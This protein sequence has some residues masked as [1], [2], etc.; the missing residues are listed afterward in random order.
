[1]SA[2]NKMRSVA[3][4][5]MSGRWPGAQNVHQFWAN[6]ANGVE[7]ISQLKEE[8]LEVGDASLWNQPN[9]VKAR[10][11]LADAEMFDASFW[12][13][14]PREAEI[15]DPQHRV[16]MECAWEA[17]EDAGY[18]AQ[19]YPGAIGVFAGCSLNTY[20]LRNLCGDREFAEEFARTYQVGSYPVLVGNHID[21]LATR[22]SYKLN[23]RGPAFT[24]QCGC[25]TSLVAVCQ[26]AQSLLTYQADMALAGGVSI[27]FPQKRGYLYQP[28]GMASPDGHCRTFDAKAQGT[29][30]GSG[31]AV[32]LLKRL[33][34]AIAEGDH[35]YA[36]IRGFALN[37]DG[38]DKVGYAAPSVEGQA[39]VIAMAQAVAGA[40]PEAISYIEA[41]GTGTPLGDPIE[42]AAA[43]KVF[44]AATQARNICA[45][46]T[47]KTNVG[48]LDIAA[49]ATGLIK[50]VL[51]LKNAQLP[52]TLH[53]E[54]PNPK[55]G[56]EN[57]PFYVNT[58]LT[59]WRKNGAPR[60]AGVSAFGVGGTNAHVVVEEAPEAEASQALREWQLLPL[61][62]KTAPALASTS[63]NLAQR[64][65]NDPALDL[66]DVAYTL[67]AGR[68]GFEQ[69]RFVV[70]RNTEDAIHKLSADAKPIGVRQDA[71]AIV[72]MFPGQ[73]SQYPGMGAELYAS[74]PEYRKWVDTCA[75]MVKADLP[76]DLREVL[77]A[78]GANQAE[79]QTLLTST[80]FAQPA[81]FTTEFALAKLWL[82]WGIRPAAMIGHSVGEFV[83]AGLGG[84]FSLEDALHLVAARGRMMQELP[85]GAML[86]VRLPESEVRSQ[87]PAALSIA[88][89]NSPALCVVSGPTSE[90]EQLEQSFTV[91]GVMARRLHTSHAFHSAM[92]E[93]VIAPF[94]E[95]AKKAALK[96]STIPYVS[97]VSGDWIK[98]EQCADPLYWA[99]HLREPVRFA[100][101]L[102][103]LWTMPSLALLEAGPGNTLSTLALQ[104][105]GK[106]ADQVVVSSLPDV[107]RT[108]HDQETILNALGRLWTSGV[109]P[110]WAEFHR[111]ERLH[112]VS[113]PTYPF[114]RKRYFIEPKPAGSP[115]RPNS[116]SITEQVSSQAA[117]NQSMAEPS[118]A[119]SSPASR[120]ERIEQQL[121]ELF[122]EQSGINAAEIDRSASFMEL[123][124]DSLFLTQAAQELQHKFG[125]KITFRQL[126]D[127]ES[128]VGAL[129]A[130]LDGKLPPE[131][132]PA[133]PMEKAAAAMLPAPATAE[134][135]PP[136]PASIGSSA[137]ESMMK[138][139]LRVMSE[140]MARQLEAL[141][142]IGA[143]QAAVARPVTSADGTP[144]KS[145]N[146]HV[147]SGGVDSVP[148]AAVAKEE[149]KAFGPYKPPAKGQSGGLTP[150]QEKHIARLIE[151]YTKK[152]AESKRLTQHYRR[153]MADPRVV[154]GFRSQWKEMVY[155]I[156]TERS[157]G[158]KLYDVD[159]NEY[160]DIL[161]GYGP[162][163]FGHK[164]KF[165]TEAVEKQLALGFE[166]GPMSPLA[167][168]VAELISEFTGMERVA[169]CNT[170]S[171]AVL[172]AMRVARTATGRNK[173]AMFTGDYHGMFDEVLVKGIKRPGSAPRSL[174]IA[175][176][177][178][179][180]AAE[181][182]VVLDYGTA[183]S[184]AYIR[185][186]ASEL[187][188]VM[189]E[190]VQSRHPNLQPREFLHEL[191][192]ITAESGAAFIFDEVVTGFRIHPSGAQAIFGIRADMATYGKIIG[193]GLPIGILTGKPQFMDTLD[194]GMWQYGD[195]S[196]P[197]VGV[198]F[199]AGTFVRHPLALAATYSV[200]QHLKEQGP[201]LQE[202]LNEKTAKM[203][204][205]L[206]A[207][208]EQRQAPVRIENFASIFYFG[209]PSDLRFASLFYYHMREQG[210]H[211]QEGFPC[212]L[213]TAHSDADIERIICAFQKSVEA[214]QADGMLPGVAQKSAVGSV[215]EAES[216]AAPRE[217]PLTESQREIWLSDQL[218]PEASCSYNESFSLKLKGGLNEA[219]LRQ[220]IQEVVHRH[221]ALRA[222]FSEDGER[223]QI[224]PELELE[225]PLLDFSGLSAEDRDRKYSEVIAHEA[226]TAFDL[227][228]GP[229]LR[230]TLLRLAPEQH[231]AVFT[232]HHIVCDG[233]STNVILDELS[234]LYSAK[235]EGR[236]C[237][238]PAPKSFLEYAREQSAAKNSVEM[239]RVEQYWLE[240]FSKPAPVLELPID[241]PRPPVKDYAGATYRAT[242]SSDP[243]RR[244]K[245]AGAQQGCTLFATLLAA[246]QLLLARLSHQDDIVVGIPA[247]AQSLLDG[248]TL[249]GHCVN[250]L[251]LRAEIAREASFA[252]FA[253]QVKRSV[254]DAYEHQT[255]TYGTLVRK[256]GIARDPSRLPLIETQFNLERIGS[257]MKFAG[258]EVEV[259]PNPKAFVNFDLFLNVVEAEDGLKLDCDYNRELFDESTI[260]RWIG[261][262][263]TLLEEFAADAQ[264]KAL[265]VPM[266][267]AAERRLL[268]EDWNATH[269]DFPAEKKLH[270]LFE[271]QAARTPDRI[272]LVF[273]DQQLTYRELD[274]RANQLARHLQAWGA[275]PESKV[276]LFIERSLEMVVGLLGILKSGA[277]YVPLDP[278]YPKSRIEY[279][280]AQAGSPVLVTQEHLANDLNTGAK[281]VL[282]DVDGPKIQVQSKTKPEEPASSANLAYVLFT[283]GSTGK[284]KGVEV[285]H[286]SLVN[287][288]SSVRKTPGISANDTVLAVTTI[289]FDVAT[290]EL[291]TPL[292]VG[293]NVVIAGRDTVTDGFKLKQEMENHA[294]TTLI[295]TPGIF[296][297][298]GEGGW[299]SHPGLKIWS[300][301]EALPRELADTLLAGGAELWNMYGPT[302]TTI[303]S[304]GCRL[305]PEPGPVPIGRPLDNTRIYVLDEFG[306]PTP[307]GVAGE[308]WIGGA[309][310]ARGYLNDAK[311]SAERFVPDPFR[312][313]D[314]RMYRTG[315]LVRYRKDGTIEFLGRADRQ[316]KLRG[317]RIELGEIESALNEARGVR[318]SAVMVR[319]DAPGDRRLV[320][321]YAAAGDAKPSPAELR[322]H[323]A[324]SLP[325]YM[326][327]SVFVKLEALPRTPNCKLDQKALPAP[328]AGPVPPA[329]AA[330]AQKPEEK[331]MS[332][333]W[334]EVLRLKEVGIDD[335]LFELGADSLHVFQ[336]VARAN[337][338]GMKVS[339]R[340][341]LQLRTIRAIVNELDKAPPAGKEEAQPPLA[342]SP[343]RAVSRDEYR[344]QKIEA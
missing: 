37:N 73:G 36:V 131:A 61:S 129:A 217:A 79:A 331:K 91:R 63:T 16:F 9:F 185:A 278:S 77:Y 34:D 209:F 205:R 117:T 42:I 119:P 55:L 65:K 338:A 285:T 296:R 286:R 41:H 274:E 190:P 293:A 146:A 137:A 92:M 174:P 339:P 135:A 200:L 112:R 108:T 229:L 156:V 107:S 166:I 253:M 158:S 39:E 337:K 71:P 239:Q 290:G 67:Q 232:S 136:Q 335:N 218:G 154:S 180:Q 344:V 281:L 279:I 155:P 230:A 178:P 3:I 199:F 59:E 169:F 113:L 196:F 114:E 57:S 275:G 24:L 307:V 240:R 206:N 60:R 159:G 118:T 85:G 277:A 20:F 150:A 184:L 122:Q 192:K 194:G 326:V 126:L 123:G 27:S 97:C 62:A 29:V 106:K 128:S 340:H 188:A 292:C 7:S 6:L 267:G 187:A 241:R 260:A 164:P 208:L 191:R 151:R 223:V 245:K 4:I 234:Q 333:I 152:T 105:P 283:S 207:Y 176:G 198:T 49:G 172:C 268:L 139:Q 96:P 216:P 140:L 300:T 2:E 28:D 287:L 35:I 87:L 10:G 5:G 163:V 247:A 23:L 280:L 1:M 30:F 69:R 138:E 100:D 244:I 98:P 115:S 243:Y 289:S 233:W 46:G 251:A 182:I 165:V 203:V 249:V 327:P 80:V 43:T 312:G 210:I 294:I 143:P 255:Y 304:V 161:N 103:C 31:A 8:E 76:R 93:P 236:S 295:A 303:W 13:M 341:V 261:H 309:G 189:V 269:T 318:E 332:E 321:Y 197:E 171:E 149:P 211:L 301:G 299:Q 225:I 148:A 84:V 153:V 26:A 221:E 282:L 177:I 19:R 147:I 141:R 18:D 252:D 21:F 336:I 14:Y 272:A 83:A 81:I 94:A 204:A 266:L 120:K 291:L 90:I 157:E 246:Y 132:V 228:R 306:E 316:I 53:F 308:M 47:V 214:L 238:L 254:L 66:A 270:E 68:R 111:H 127:Q 317:F 99:R 195:D 258:L 297:L 248:E 237:A 12:G 32:V 271:E 44:R 109:Q 179:P 181:N 323:L 56:L 102:A 124:F 322:S 315:D 263:K 130:Y 273:E 242:I 125:V 212:F 183:E 201:Q 70:A 72:F 50:T 88:A 193:G 329:L 343:I 33:E 116:D 310:I 220:A 133:V 313:G 48:H 231:L 162:T 311:L 95:L 284:P 89:V 104:H 224:H 160:I 110:D 276:G 144:A 40:S 45:I 213:T 75:D 186:H 342:G 134:L 257:G 38:S 288:I 170:G 168:K 22:I 235:V 305:Q 325:D 78:D 265:R 121:L 173:I 51:A 227:M 82:S 54:K 74:E 319:E 15:T 302:E 167:G 222:T 324:Q 142:G 320:A 25:S 11:V 145:A 264:R 330:E 52:P 334:V 64:L 250:F 17:L 175:P 262:Y 256:L 259:D 314:A 101:G 328:E 58:Q 202:R 298:L 219:A 226:R 215:G 86:S